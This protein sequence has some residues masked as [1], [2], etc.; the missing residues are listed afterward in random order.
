MLG[1]RSFRAGGT[2]EG[3]VVAVLR[4]GDAFAVEKLGNRE[5][6]EVRVFILPVEG[7]VESRGGGFGAH[8]FGGVFECDE[9]TDFGFFAFDDSAQNRLGKQRSFEDFPRPVFRLASY[10]IVRTWLIDGPP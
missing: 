6:L 1:L 2:L 9:D 7:F 5:D 8:G 4:V 3:D 10:S